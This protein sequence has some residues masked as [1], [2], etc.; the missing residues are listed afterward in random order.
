[1]VFS[2]LGDFS[3]WKDRRVRELVVAKGEGVLCRERARPMRGTGS[4]RYE[5]G[6]SGKGVRGLRTGKGGE[7]DV[8]LNGLALSVRLPQMTDAVAVLP[9]TAERIL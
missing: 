4:I 9:W 5:R 2:S 6:Q 8:R 1:M 7:G 3:F